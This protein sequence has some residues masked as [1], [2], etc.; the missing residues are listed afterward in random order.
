MHACLDKR[1][2]AGFICWLISTHPNH[3]QEIRVQVGILFFGGKGYDAI[4]GN[5]AIGWLALGVAAFFIALSVLDKKNSRGDWVKIVKRLATIYSSIS[6]VVMTIWSFVERAGERLIGWEADRFHAVGN[7]RVCNARYCRLVNNGKF[8][9][10]ALRFSKVFWRSE[11][12]SRNTA[13]TS[14]EGFSVL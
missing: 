9:D 12:P 1:R 2:P 4:A 11:E 7:L 13:V 8:N 5:P 6:L 3:E 10:P 14:V